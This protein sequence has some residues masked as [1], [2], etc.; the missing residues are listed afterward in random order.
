MIKITG[1]KHTA[2]HFGTNNRMEKVV[3]SDFM[4]GSVSGNS[5]YLTGFSGQWYWRDLKITGDNAPKWFKELLKDKWSEYR[6]HELNYCIFDPKTGSETWEDG[7]SCFESYPGT[8]EEFEDMYPS[9]LATHITWDFRTDCSSDSRQLTK[10]ERTRWFQNWKRL[11]LLPADVKV[12]DIV[13]GNLTMKMGRIPNH[14][15]MATCAGRYIYEQPDTVRNTLKLVDHGWYFI[16]A[17]VLCQL[18]YGDRGHQL[19]S[20]YMMPNNTTAFN[21]PTAIY[22]QIA[23][24]AYTFNKYLENK[25]HDTCHYSFNWWG[26]VAKHAPGE[27]H[28]VYKTTK[29]INNWDDLKSF[30]PYTGELNK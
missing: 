1:L 18:V 7:G 8:V 27:K 9:D 11:K 22:Q 4:I 19:V 26:S 20:K 2:D 10:K 23:Y 29:S 6:S 15:Y 13:E 17:T 16:T 3:G 25:K 28:K 21:R 24:V 5:I 30:N 12:A 14:V